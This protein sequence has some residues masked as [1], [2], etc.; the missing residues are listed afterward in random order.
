MCTEGF[1]QYKNKGI[2]KVPRVISITDDQS[3]QT[4]KERQFLLGMF[5]TPYEARLLQS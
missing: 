4:R 5:Y 3:Y 2:I 1:L